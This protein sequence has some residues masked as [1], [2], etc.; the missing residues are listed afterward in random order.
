MFKKRIFIYKISLRI[1]EY[2]VNEII[3]DAFFFLRIVLID[4]E[5]IIFVPVQVIACAEPHQ[6]FAV[7][8]NTLNNALGKPFLGRHWAIARRSNE[9]M[10]IDSFEIALGIEN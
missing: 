9:R 1:F 4:D 2:I 7:L 5:R 8:L 3:A 10:L 6:S